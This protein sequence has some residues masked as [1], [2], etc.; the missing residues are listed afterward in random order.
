MRLRP[1][2]FGVLHTVIC[3]WTIC[4]P[5]CSLIIF[6]VCCFS[7]WCAWSTH[8]VMYLSVS[9]QVPACPVSAIYIQ[10]SQ[11]EIEIQTINKICFSRKPK[12]KF[13]DIIL[14]WWFSCSWSFIPLSW[15]I[16]TTSSSTFWE[17]TK[18]LFYC[19]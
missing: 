17:K 15:E 13:A 12:E 3:W 1:D 5:L 9:M 6:I 2:C 14:E 11:R 16:S 19:Q 7:S 8:L 18:N 10:P 4:V